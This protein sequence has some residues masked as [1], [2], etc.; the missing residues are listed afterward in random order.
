MGTDT[1]PAG[2]GHQGQ[3]PGENEERIFAGAFCDRVMGSSW[4]LKQKPDGNEASSRVTL[5]VMVEVAGNV[6]D[7][8]L[9]LPGL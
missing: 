1:R 5:E 4:G 9:R 3:M 8:R 6:D 2:R 7:R